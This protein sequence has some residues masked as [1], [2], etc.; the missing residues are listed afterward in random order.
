MRQIRPRKNFRLETGWRAQNIANIRAK[1][2]NERLPFPDLGV[3]EAK[4]EQIG[5]AQYER[6][7]RHYS[8]MEV[9]ARARITNLRLTRDSLADN[10]K[11]LG[12]QTNR[13]E[14]EIQRN[15]RELDKVKEALSIAIKQWEDYERNFLGNVP[16]LEKRY[17]KSE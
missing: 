13:D 17:Q 14:D 4:R 3:S 16:K 10:I 6:I 12:Q 9:E 11:Y 1:N 7:R 2:K 5:R 15:Q 8:T